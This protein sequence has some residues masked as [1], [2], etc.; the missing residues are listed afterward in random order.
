MTS[1]A[2]IRA[3]RDNARRST[4]P[5]TQ[6]GKRRSRMNALRHGG[7][8]HHTDR[9]TAG[10]L[11]ESFVEAGELFEAIIEDL[12]PTSTLQHSQAASI[13][14]QI[15]NQKRVFR[16]TQSLAEA[17]A[18]GDSY[19]DF[20]GGIRHRYRGYMMLAR[21]LETRREAAP[22]DISYYSLA[23]GLCTQYRQ[24]NITPPAQANSD[25]PAVQAGHDRAELLRILRA[26]H[27]DLDKA[28]DAVMSELDQMADRAD[29]ETRTIR[30][31]EAHKLLKT[32]EKA[33]GLQDR[34]A[35]SI[36]RDLKA[37]RDLRALEAQLA[38]PTE[39]DEPRNEPNL[40]E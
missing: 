34:V 36:A 23:T 20:V 5:T 28:Y 7:Y 40:N 21:A 26:I 1:D 19:D 37:Y 39:G 27:G 29:A 30:G 15:V 31:I 14:Q 35:R 8:L 32:F 13:A 4:G 16:L 10:I 2:Q 11:E 6:E 12:A 24:L 18:V 17:D 38:D 3:N 33:T 22:Y 9:I 25:D